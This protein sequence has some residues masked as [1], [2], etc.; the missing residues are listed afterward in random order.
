MISDTDCYKQGTTLLIFFF[1]YT[2]S[3]RN[4]VKFWVK[5]IG[6]T[7]LHTQQY[8]RKWSF[9]TDL[10]HSFPILL[11]CMHTLTSSVTRTRLQWNFHNTDTIGTLPNCSVKL[12]G[13]ALTVLWSSLSMQCDRLGPDQASVIRNR[14]VSLIRRSSKYIV[15]VSKAD[16]FGPSWASV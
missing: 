2:N 11:L 15:H 16:R 3:F 1:F 8:L 10:Q 5:N 12:R 6:Q 9:L 7:F 14:E 4:W 13:V